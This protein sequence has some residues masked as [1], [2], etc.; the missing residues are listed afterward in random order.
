M[1]EAPAA[2]RPA[3]TPASASLGSSSLDDHA[4]HL[5]RGLES[6]IGIPAAD[7]NRVDILRNGD[8]TFPAILDAIRGAEQT[9]DLVT[10]QLGTGAIVDEICHALAGRARAGL[11]VRVLVDAIGSRWLDRSLVSL[12]RDAG[13]DFEW[14]RPPSNLR[15]WAHENRTHRKVMVVDG[16]VGF[17]GGVNFSEEWCGDAR[18]PDEWR[19]THLRIEGPA[20]DG[21]VAAFSTDWVD[22]GRQ[23][24]ELEDTFLDQDR[25]GTTP[26]QVV[27]GAPAKGWSDIANVFATLLI[28]A[29]RRVRIESAYFAPDDHFTELLVDAACRGVDVEVLLPGPNAHSRFV[30]LAA[31][32]QFEKL[33]DA[34]VRIWSY[35]PTMLHSKVVLVDD[36]VA[37]VG[38]ANFDR[39][40]MKLNHEI[41]I[42]IPDPDVVSV[43]D[44]QLDEDL[45]RSTLIREARW[46]RRPVPQRLLETVVAPFRGRL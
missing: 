33:L 27:R 46:R 13:A 38:S 32:A 31:E 36:A 35:Q 19:D 22:A 3:P 8:E 18:D 44:R 7:G 24:C 29:Q 15:F 41:E 26:V 45:D 2:D 28:L 37:C 10:F 30:Q 17:A 34:E 6:L 42:V 23:A 4:T 14:F 43:L 5:R 1:T 20:V 9:I 39:R 11:R 16:C 25:A 40:S 12:L 21:L